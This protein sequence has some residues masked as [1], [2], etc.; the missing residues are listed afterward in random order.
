ME[1]DTNKI[2][3]EIDLI[4]ILSAINK[5]RVL[6]G[7][8]TFLFAI[9]SA[10]YALSLPNVYTS[11]A[12]LEISSKSQT[13]N[14]GGANNLQMALNATIALSE[15]SPSD[16]A[17]AQALLVSRQTI[18]SIM[19]KENIV[20]E[21]FEFQS[22][23]PLTKTSFYNDALRDETTGLKKKP[24][25][26]LV[27]NAL[28]SNLQVNYEKSTGFIYISFSH[29]SPIFSQKMINLLVNEVNS[30]AREKDLAE[31]QE[32]LDYLN[33]KYIETNIENI[34]VTIGALIES[35]LKKQMFAFINQ[36]YIVSFIDPPFLPEQI[37]A[38][39][40][41]FITIAGTILGIVLSIIYVVASYFFR[42]SLV[43]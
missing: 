39:N 29:G 15:D 38:P 11:D 22:Y 21:L 36:D 28:M 2:N 13:G 33:Q 43:K 24:S 9:G 19:E 31:T 35:Q 20:R 12:N 7:I 25:Y 26:L 4:E 23:D 37:S 10:I 32:S 17:K 30:S 3:D 34:R 6:I 41:R 16:S 14:G 5:K 40:R 18:K 42:K 8:S 1:N 27:H